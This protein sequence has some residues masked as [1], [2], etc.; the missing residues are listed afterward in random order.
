MNTRVPG[1]Y[2]QWLNFSDEERDRIHR[3]VWNVYARDGVGIAAIAAGRLSLASSVKVL[4]VRI[5]TYHDGELVLHVCVSDDDH[6]KVPEPLGQR[7]EGFRV[8]WISASN[9]G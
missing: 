1:S 9:W 3:N 2:E 6:P 4:D 8:I 5:G 7:F